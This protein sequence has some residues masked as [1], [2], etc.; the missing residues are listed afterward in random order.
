MNYIDDVELTKQL[1]EE[2]EQYNKGQRKNPSDS[3]IKKFF[4]I[5]EKILTASKYNGY[6]KDYK[7][8]FKS[9]ANLL[10]IRYWMKFNPY[11]VK[12]NIDN[13]N[14]DFDIAA[15]PNIDIDIKGDYKKLKKEL[16]G[17]LTY[18]TILNITAIHTIIN[19]EKKFRNFKKNL[20]HQ[21]FNDLKKDVSKWS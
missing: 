15:N 14:I 7:D 20:Y 21:T 19:K 4:L 3:L 9:E 1:M 16:K 6:T 5:Q 13:D 18:F 11:K 8:E 2:I 17:A 10:F 12:N